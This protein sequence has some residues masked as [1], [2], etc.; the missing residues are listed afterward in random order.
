ML[1]YD[2]KTN[3]MV[4]PLGT[5]AD[6]IAF[7][8]KLKSDRQGAEQT[9]YRIRVRTENGI[10]WDSGKVVSGKSL[11]IAYEGKRESTTRYYW[12]VCVWD[13][14]GEA[15]ESEEAWFETGLMGKCENVWSGAQWIGNPKGTVNTSA[16]DSYKISGTVSGK[17]IGLAINA[18]NKDNYIL[19]ETAK[20]Y[21]SVY[22]I[23]D[24]AWNN[25]KP[26]KNL[27]GK[28][29][30]NRTDKY[31]FVLSVARRCVTLEIDGKTVI[32]NAEILPENN[33][34]QPRKN[35][36][37]N[38][39]FNQLDGKAAVENLKIEC[40]DIVLKEYENFA[41][42]NAFE[43]INP[44]SAV[45]VRKFFDVQR[46]VK[47]ARLYASARGF[48]ESYI[49]G[50]KVG[51]DY[52]NP[53]FTDYRYRIQYQTYDVT[54]MIKNGKN[55]IGAAVGKGYYNGFVGYNGAHIYGKENSF[56]AKLVIEYENG[57]K[58]V[59]VTDSS[60]QFTD[61]GP[62]MDSDYLDGEYYD[63][64]REFD[65][66]DENDTRWV[67]CGVKEW[68]TEVIPTNGILDNVEFILTSQCGPMAR[69]I[70][71]FDGKFSCEMP[72]NHFVYD[73]GQNMVGTVRI[74]LKGK[75]GQSVKIRYG[76]MAY[77]DGSVYIANLRS[78]ANTDVYVL[79]GDGE[80]VFEP[81]FV[82]HGF[83]YVE[84]TGNGCTISR[85]MIMDVEGLV[86]ANIADV[87]GG[88]ECSNSLVNKL[89]SNIQ[90]GLKGNSLLV[91]TDC[92]QRNERMGWTGDGQ[93]F[94]RTGAYNMDMKAFTDKWLLDMVDGQMMYNKN[95]AV[96]DT[97][98]L[99]GD[100]RKDGC[101][102]W[103]DAAVIV[104]WE[105]YM[106]YGDVRVLEDNYEMMKK[107]V[108]YQSRSDR[109]HCGLRVVD[110]VEMPDKSDFSTEPY[111]QVQQ[112][113]GD[114]LTF[115][116]STPYIYS[117]TAYA[118]H[119]A[120]LLSRIAE[121]LGK[122]DD[123]RRYRTRFENIKKAF[124]EAWVKEDGS[125]AYW[126]EVS[127][128]T[129][130]CG[131]ARSIDGSVS[132]YTYYSDKEN[133]QHHP[134]QTAYALAIAFDLIDGEK[135]AH[136]ARCFRDTIIRN[137]GKL[138]VGFLGISH[139]APALSKVGFDDMAFALLEQE[140]NPSW[141]YS[142]KNGATTIWERWDSYIAET[143]TFG[144]VAMNSFNHYSYGAIGE[145]LMSD[146]LGIKPLKAGYKK[147][148]LAPKWGGTLTYAKG[149][150]VSPYGQIKSAWQRTDGK[151]K[152]ECTVPVNTT[153]IL[154][155]DGKEYNLQSGKYS[156]EI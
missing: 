72:K 142:V 109:Q 37:M 23:S 80:E 146:V 41:L 45:N 82:S 81:S 44:V 77:R 122:T 115:D 65:W 13:E 149:F 42:E 137:N 140:E 97:A 25:G 100:N 12:S 22:E 143:D 38:I 104:P 120:D 36:M 135:T 68:Q 33:P 118:A 113:R 141:L 10:A 59:I 123:A 98:P 130:H 75:R 17:Q 30:I 148:I 90:W 155:L 145:W 106:A 107:W 83:R 102:G 96:P 19:I 153:A 58:D 49:N 62:V 117:A 119:S 9:A 74:R 50:E 76:E 128:M 24:N 21:V 61:R 103:G 93:V 89:Q 124:N 71:T 139:L 133:S 16:V 73:M 79:K 60:W 110:G 147:F 32:D 64:R 2:M 121:I 87:T 105:M 35:A 43:L 134:S 26:Y 28:Y 156:F 85:D 132:R 154:Y 15:H 3:D 150:H 5:D 67:N 52:Y 48:Y 136:T 11:Y 138:T 94:A 95:G 31:S 8:W 66:C 1:I 51:E 69:V 70:D 34:V 56:I 53:S 91:L 131:E 88:F 126:G 116:S 127:A 101:G 78:A 108:D 57:E 6:K 39:G 99:G 55:V 7:S 40:D 20:A 114:H 14:K 112:C 144:D 129:P 152:Y 47:K 84:I 4:C 151:I 29:D 18:R 111:L 27:L 63:A 92:P 125:I 86:I 54:D 46:T